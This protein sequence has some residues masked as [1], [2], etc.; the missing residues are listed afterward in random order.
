MVTDLVEKDMVEKIVPEGVAIETSEFNRVCVREDAIS[1]VPAIAAEFSSP[2][3][4]LPI[5]S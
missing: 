5:G 3:S 4:Q 1:P 2:A